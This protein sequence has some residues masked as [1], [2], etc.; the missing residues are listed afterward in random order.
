M[1][2]GRRPASLPSAVIFRGSCMSSAA[3]KEG[4]AAAPAAANPPSSQPLV[5]Q[6]I[7]DASLLQQAGW[8]MGP[9]MAQA[10]HAT[11]AVLAQT[12]GQPQTQAYLAPGNLPHMRKVVLKAPA[13]VGLHALSQQL[14][15]AAARSQDDGKATSDGAA[16][17]QHH[18][19][20]EQPE[21][22]PTVLALAPNTRPSVG[23]CVGSITAC[24]AA[25][26]TLLLGIIAILP[27]GSQ[28]SSQQMLTASRLST[29]IREER[30]K[31]GSQL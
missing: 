13:G 6:L 31:R 4:G 2:F 18:L 26:L 9:M 1:L 24:D 21:D 29:T 14:D 30:L 8:S 27:P 5:M 22:I 15:E 10:A 3:T 19:W 28:E 16:F 23:R 11:S 7:V 12:Y 20:I 25:G 17:P